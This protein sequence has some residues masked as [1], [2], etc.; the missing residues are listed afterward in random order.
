M[1]IRKLYIRGFG[2]IKEFEL[3]PSKN[4]NVIY[5]P[6]ESGKSTI[7]AFIKAILFGL[8]GGRA[9]REGTAAEAR[10]YRPWGNS[11]YG[12]YINFEMD[13]LTSYRLDRDFDKNSVKLYDREFND[14]TGLYSAARDGK[15]I[16]EKLLGVNEGLFERTVYIRQLGTKIDKASSKELIDRI[17]NICQSGYEDISYKKAH[18]ALKEA[19]K[20]QV[21]TERSFT[22]PLDIINRRLGELGLMQKKL[23]EEE[24]SQTAAKCELERMDSEIAVLAG[25]EELFTLAG[26]FLDARERLGLQ[27]RNAEEMRFLKAGAGL[28]RENIARL[29]GEA[30]VLGQEVAETT[31]EE[32]KLEEDFNR[33]SRTVSEEDVKN[34]G[35]QV[36]VLSIT[37]ILTLSAAIGCALGTVIFNLLPLYFTAIPSLAFIIAGAFS[38]VKGNRFRKL[39]REQLELAGREKLLWQQL[40]NIRNVKSAAS[41]QLA[42]LSERLAIEKLQY[43]QQV[44]RLENIEP[45]LRQ[46]EPEQ[47]E[48][49]VDTLS[50]EI[51][52]LLE[53]LGVSGTLPKGEAILAESII[54][55]PAGGQRKE[56][57]RVQKFYAGQ[58]QQKRIAKAALELQLKNLISTADTEAVE[59]EF[60]RLAQQKKALEQRGEALQLAMTTLEEA[61]REVRKKFL[62]IMNKAFSSTFSGLTS[63]KYTEIKAGDNLSIMLSDPGSETMVPVPVLSN[64]TADQLYL[65]LRVAISEAVLKNNEQL[66]LIL[67]E[68][69][70]QYDDIRTENALR[71]INELGRKQ[72]VMIFTCKQREV[73]MI[74]ELTGGNACKIC[75][76]T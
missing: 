23:R 35:K 4:I 62:P 60:Y 20:S 65:A 58:L 27:K 44:R 32:S 31:L 33:L 48:S 59:Q 42:G 2:K 30:A 74:S 11:Q 55:N 10:R 54:E 3:E 47:L 25:I 38:A 75:S 21:G 18:T 71:L 72:Q 45:A 37:G 73:E 13:A 12:G 53:A 61:A 29:T 50:M 36:K 5:G 49:R 39:E 70:A 17:S 41:N 68:P 56:V 34:L 22:R 64:G 51:I 16:A 46:Q 52:R 40:E 69:F 8:K 66:P 24:E 26:E 15:G 1:K 57:D 76:L 28:L 7:M 43:E 9:D 67:D 14:V 6:N 63:Q 19:L